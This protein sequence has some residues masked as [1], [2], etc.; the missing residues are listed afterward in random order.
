MT[1][2]MQYDNCAVCGIQLEPSGIRG[3]VGGYSVCPDCN[4]RRATVDVELTEDEADA[5]RK[6]IGSYHPN[7][8][9][10]RA[11]ISGFDSEL[12]QLLST[13]RN[14]GLWISKPEADV[15]R[16][17]ITKIEA[18]LSTG[19][20]ITLY[21]PKGIQTR[22]MGNAL[23][24]CALSN[25]HGRSGKFEL[26]DTQAREVM[27]VVDRQLSNDHCDNRDRNAY[28]RI[29]KTIEVARSLA[30]PGSIEYHATA[31]QIT[32]IAPKCDEPVRMIWFDD[33]SE[34]KY[35][36]CC[37]THYGIVKAVA[38]AL[39]QGDAEQRSLDS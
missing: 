31:E 2:A 7:I 32:C 33:R 19:E 25:P 29:K 8:K 11:R 28:A 35:A 23:Y 13:L 12:T 5:V 30:Q 36:P 16:S 21:L 26:T 24:G 22:L 4:P 9:V 34:D 18:A 1:T 37:A 10:R 17:A 39:L 6:G 14:H 27:Q 20:T 38:V 15:V 3:D